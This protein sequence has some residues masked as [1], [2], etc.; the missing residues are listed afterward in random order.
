MIG[1]AA[2]PYIHFPHVVPFNGREYLKRQLAKEGIGYEDL[3]N[4]ISSC[5][6]PKRMQELANSL[7]PARILLF[8]SK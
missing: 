3:A 6:N 2:R 1:S 8:L 7:T 5:E 4:G